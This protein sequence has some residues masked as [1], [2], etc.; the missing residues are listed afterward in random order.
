MSI[1]DFLMICF[2]F[3]PRCSVLANITGTDIYRDRK[4]YLC[5]SMFNNIIYC[6]YIINIYDKI[7]HR[8]IDWSHISH[9]RSFDFV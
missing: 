1:V 6:I 9:L 5:V 2:Y 8:T 7:A 4:D 3:S